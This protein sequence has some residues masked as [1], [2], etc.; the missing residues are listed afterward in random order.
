M[1]KGKN[2]IVTGVSKGIG[3]ETT[4]LLLE[5]GVKVVG[6]SRSKPDLEHPDFHFV[7]V[8][9][10]DWEQVEKGYSESVKSIGENIHILIN[11]A[12]YG[13]MAPI[14]EM[15]I[16]DWKGMFDINV[17]GLMYCTKVV[18]P[19]MKKMD[20]GHIINISSIAGLNGLKNLS[21]YVATK[22]AVTGFSHSL[23]LELR[24]WGIK[25]STVYPGSVQTN[26]FDDID[27]IEA[28]ENMMQPQDIAK[29][30]INLI[31]THPNLLS[32]DL[33]LRPLRPKGK[34][35]P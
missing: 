25:V 19:S 11:N 27:A 26:F 24:D 22:H 30:I 20:Q 23:M 18:V 17:H 34:P 33:E 14:D 3:L 31:D 4:K 8:D 21:G 35:K 29:A 1:L 7:K 15:S 5:E 6:W 28:N 13:V 32:A 12:G 9:V 10:S 16:S 2:A